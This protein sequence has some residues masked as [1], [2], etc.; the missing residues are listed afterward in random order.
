MIVFD[1]KCGG[2]HVFEA[3]FASS[4]AYAEQRDRHFIACPVC[5]DVEIG[6]AVMAPSVGA[7]GNRGPDQPT[8]AAVKAALK[9]LAT[10]QAEMLKKSTWVGPAFAT[11]ARA[12]HAGDVPSAPI[13]GQ[14]SVDDV[15]KLTDEGVPIAPLPLPVLPPDTSH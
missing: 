11:H 3:W 2:G 15:K 10:A 13:H 4:T 9:H 7:K 14:A 5:G 6:K 8:P 1:L 12:M